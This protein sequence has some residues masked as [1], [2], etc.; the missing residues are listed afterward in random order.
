M[1]N[2]EISQ[3][4][5][6]GVAG[7][8][9]KLKDSVSRGL[10]FESEDDYE[11]AVSQ[12]LLNDLP[13][14]TMIYTPSTGGGG[15]G[16]GS[17]TVVE[18]LSDIEAMAEFNGEAAG[19]KAV[20]TL[21]QAFSD[22]LTALK[23]TAIAQAVGATAQDT[24]ISLITKLSNIVNR[25]SGSATLNESKTSSNIPEGYYNGTGSVSIDSNLINAIG[26]TK[27]T[28]VGQVTKANAETTLPN[29]ASKIELYNPTGWHDCISALTGGTS[30]GFS[31]V[32]NY[33]CTV[34]A[35]G[36]T[37]GSG[38][39]DGIVVKN[40]YGSRCVLL[41]TVIKNTSTGSVTQCG[42][43]YSSGTLPTLVSTGASRTQYRDGL[44][45][46]ISVPANYIA[47]ICGPNIRI[48]GA[49]WFPIEQD[50]TGTYEWSSPTQYFNN[51]VT[52]NLGTTNN[53]RWVR[54]KNNIF[55]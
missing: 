2:N 19:A 47:Y 52:L 43:G 41:F 34:E 51:G 1:P 20:K 42:A 54:N 26:T 10:F 28:W 9:Y 11:E 15:G 48:V 45:F 35:N 36:F 38:D 8:E 21:K 6:T 25:G 46:I 4:N 53:Y 49:H 39:F 18:E 44:A 5:P 33:N 27:N 16:G 30:W 24:F 40:D 14:G 22:A 31:L 55:I 32:Q 23:N 37:T 7:G 50:Q 12:G 13:D 29:I 17:T 3:I